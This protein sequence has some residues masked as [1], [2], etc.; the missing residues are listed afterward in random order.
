[1]EYH[2]VALPFLLLIVLSANVMATEEILST[3]AICEPGVLEEMPQHIKRVCIALKN[4]NQLSST[5][6]EY[7][8]SQALCKCAVEMKFVNV[9][10]PLR[11]ARPNMFTFNFC[12][13][14]LT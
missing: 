3:P 2:L 14:P 7:I 11:E 4:S 8:R 1:M 10:L 6:N 9:V 13:S 5:L 12:L